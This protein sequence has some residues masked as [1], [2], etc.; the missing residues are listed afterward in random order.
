MWNL[1]LKR[2]MQSQFHQRSENYEVEP[3]LFYFLGILFIQI[4]YN[5]GEILMLFETMFLKAQLAAPVKLI[6]PCI[7]WH[8]S[9]T[10]YG[11]FNF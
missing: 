6:C 9:V 3:V 2:I 5:F 11:Y 1:V 7:F 4:S 10:F 8:Y